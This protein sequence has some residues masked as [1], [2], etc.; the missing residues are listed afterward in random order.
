MNFPAVS[1]DD[2]PDDPA[3][4]VG[5]F[6]TH[7]LSSITDQGAQFTPDPEGIIHGAMRFRDEQRTFTPETDEVSGIDDRGDP[8][9]DD[10]VVR[11]YWGDLS[12][13]GETLEIILFPETEEIEAG[14]PIGLGSAVGSGVGV[15]FSDYANRTPETIFGSIGGEM[16]PF[17]TNR[18]AGA[19]G[20][21]G[22]TY[23]MYLPSRDLPTI[24]PGSVASNTMKGNFE[25]IV[26]HFGFTTFFGN[27]NAF[28]KL[29]NRNLNLNPD[30]Q[31][32]ISAI[33][34]PFGP[35]VQF[36]IA[37][38][39]GNAQAQRAPLILVTMQDG[40]AITPG[41]EIPI[42]R[43]SVALVGWEKFSDFSNG[44]DPDFEG[45]SGTV[46]I[47]PET[48][49]TQI[50]QRFTGEFDAKIAAIGRCAEQPECT[51]DD[52]CADGEI[53]EENRCVTAECTVDDDCADGEICD[54]GR[55]IPDG[56][57]TTAPAETV[58]TVESSTGGAETT[59]ETG[60]EGTEGTSGG[61]MVTETPAG[62]AAAT[63]SGDN[64]G[65]GCGCVTVAGTPQDPSGLPFFFGIGLLFFL[66][67]RRHFRHRG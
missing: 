26:V 62:T 53:C 22:G 20:F 13:Q 5:N 59:A 18:V 17:C 24:D 55:C 49:G 29:G 50:N 61:E 38:F 16:I 28:G 7:N 1:L 44:A 47:Y 34:F 41:A 58:E 46:R 66:G 15:L 9:T 21:S 51:V 65:G 4:A 10:D 11:I 12:N 36:L 6:F 60:G 42:D 33:S 3:I 43:Q 57:G 48:T 40:E 64:G 14:V 30:D 2:L 63:D 52:D 25:T 27:G 19:E 23:K 54:A 56:G 37:N 8:G 32:F 67:M 35:G 45:C 31:N 39:T